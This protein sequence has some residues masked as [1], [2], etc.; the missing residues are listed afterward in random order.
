VTLAPAEV[1]VA[2]EAYRQG[3]EPF[4]LWLWLPDY[5]DP[6]DY[7]EFLP[8]G[9][10][11]KRLNWTDE[12]ADADLLAL[13]DQLKTA[14]DPAERADLFQKMQDMLMESGPY[15]PVLQ[16]GLQIGLSSQIDGFVYNPQW[17][18]DVS[19]ISKK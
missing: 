9:V 7:V 6:L 2:L 8:G 13:R 11:G 10:V 17:R 5:R 1:Q 16:P 15:A 18:V 12:N 3:T 4:G 19:L 14:V